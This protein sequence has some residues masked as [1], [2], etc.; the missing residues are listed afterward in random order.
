MKIEF[1]QYLKGQKELEE[2]LIQKLFECKLS[3]GKC[4]LI[5]NWAELGITTV[6]TLLGKLSKFHLNWY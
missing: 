2:V 1:F 3:M 6:D 4:L 5:L